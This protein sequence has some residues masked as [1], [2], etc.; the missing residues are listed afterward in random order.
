MSWSIDFAPVLPIWL[1]AGLGAIGLV[2]VVLAVYRRAAAAWLRALAVAALTIALLN[3]VVVAEERDPLPT[4]VALVVDRSASQTLENR[5]Q[6]TDTAATALTDR[7]EAMDGIDVRTITVPQ[8]A[9]TDGTEL[10]A[11]VNAGLADVPPDRVGAVIMLTDGE[12]HDTPQT[13]ADLG[14][15]PLHALIT[16]RPD[17]ID[18]RVVIDAAPRFGIVD[19]QQTITY[20]V[21]D[22]GTRDSGTVAV[23]IYRDGELMRQDLATI[24]EPQTYDFTVPHAGNMVFEFVAAPLD[25][26]LTDINNRSVVTLDGV[27]Q[28]LRVLLVSGE[29]HVGERTWRD[30]LKS[31]PSVDLIHFTIL[32][33]AEKFDATPQNELALIAFPTQEL[34]AQ[35][36]NDFDLVIFD[37]YQDQGPLPPAYFGNIA[38]YVSDGGALLI[39]AG[40]DTAG[41]TSIYSTALADVLPATPTGTMIEVPYRPTITDLGQRHPVTRDL[42]GAQSDPPAWSRWFRLAETVNPTGDVVMD[43]ADGLPLLVLGHEGDGRVAMLMSDQAWLWA[44]GY[45]G[46]GPYVDLLR[47]V[48]HWLMQ[49]PDLAEEALRATADNGTLTIERQTMGDTVDPVTVQAPDGTEQQ[50]VLTEAEPGLWRAQLS[51]DAIGL[52]R[53]EQGDRVAVVSVGPPNPREFVDPRSTQAVLQPV[54]DDSNGHIGRIGADGADLPRIVAINAG[55]NYGGGDWLGIRMTDAS[56]LL[57]IN[58][59]PLMAGFL[60]LAILAGLLALTWFREGR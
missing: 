23:N 15:A 58:R 42:P 1:I 12:V 59:F 41:P 21:V 2:L 43:G 5:T 13:A 8:N 29:P 50:V 40:P 14:G 16:G 48:A 47:R 36:I 26:E 37:R 31:D 28:N 32:R 56:T 25:G 27:R 38:R 52:W 49:E 4:V 7:L 9:G 44:R 19:E 24:G 34:F 60:G 53:V 17:E 51:A 10:F 18:R 39:A 3:P 35:K 54:V 20:R 57:G 55:S 11:A 33:P 6:A 22:G 46:G 30:L 45:E